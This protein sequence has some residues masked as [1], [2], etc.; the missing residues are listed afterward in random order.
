MSQTFKFCSAIG[1]IDAEG[2]MKQVHE[3]LVS[4]ERWR[5]C[6]D[7]E[8]E[9]MAEFPAAVKEAVSEAKV[10]IIFIVVIIIIIIIITIVSLLA[11]R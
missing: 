8:D 6:Q 4:N 7:V 1:W 3:I 5:L 9:D 10:N 2:N 11:R